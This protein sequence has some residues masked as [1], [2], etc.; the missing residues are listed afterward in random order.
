MVGHVSCSGSILAERTASA[1]PR[2]FLHSACKTMAAAASSSGGVAPAA[3]AAP[4]AGQP[5]V[6][7]DAAA[8][9]SGSGHALQVRS[10]ARPDERWYYLPLINDYKGWTGCERCLEIHG[11][12]HPHA[13]LPR[14]EVFFVRLPVRDGGPWAYFTP[15]CRD[16]S[17]NVYGLCCCHC[18]DVIMRIC[19][20]QRLQCHFV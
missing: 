12:R 17:K 18:K 6:G 20:I 8:G 1:G 9:S 16:E 10:P 3:G 13:G 5:P 15:C 4:G 7:H 11:T 14:D 19:Q 2:S